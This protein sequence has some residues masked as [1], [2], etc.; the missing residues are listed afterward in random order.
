MPDDILSPYLSE[1]DQAACLHTLALLRSLVTDKRRQLVFFVG[2]GISIS[3]GMPLV[4]DLLKVLLMDALKSSAPDKAESDTPVLEA[5]KRASQMLGFEITLNS[6]WDSCPDAIK[7]LF[8]SLA[9]FEEK[10]CFPNN[11]HK[12]L[13]RWL[14]TS[15]VVLTTNYDR[16][17]ERTAADEAKDLLIRYTEAVGHASFEHWR[18]DLFQG[19][20]LFK[21]HGSF[22]EP[23]SCLGALEQVGT[24][25]SG[26]RGELLA[27]IAEE[28]PICFIGW[29]GVDPD[30]PLLLTEILSK[31]DSVPV[32]WVHYEGGD[33]KQPK[34]LAQCLSGVPEPLR[35]I[36]DTHPLITDADRL[37]AEMGRWLGWGIDPAINEQQE[38][39]L[40]SPS[41]IPQFSQSLDICTRTYLARFVGT[42]LRHARE[43][44][45][46]LEILEVA[47]TL[48]KSPGES[49]AALSEKSLTL[50]AQGH[51]SQQQARTLL[52]RTHSKYRQASFG[53]LSMTV[54]ASRRRPWL[55]LRLPHLFRGYALY[56]DELR[57]SA[58]NLQGERRVALHEALF[59]LYLGKLRLQLVSWIGS[60]ARP[61]ASWVLEPFNI[62]RARIDDAGDIHI[63]S[64]IDVL[65]GRSLALA[66][67]GFCEE[68][69][70]D[71]PEVK[72]LCGILAD[73]PRTKHFF[74]NQ[75]PKLEQMCTPPSSKI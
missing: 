74:E 42:A 63:H 20:C 46:A 4:P 12:F 24:K 34:G 7:Q 36:A 2:A 72:R 35:K 5:I 21:V 55:L 37:F 29:R 3:A 47:H 49:S 28:R 8:H 64:R 13:E 14:S 56:I 19:K 25:I 67:F 59:H 31:K 40:A 71:I 48:A 70:R 58:Y 23:E 50:W 6:L 18:E 1:I 68:A 38:I 54:V 15:G 66:R 53:M 44:E 39:P 75:L 60:L 43:F 32:I 9:D 69:W 11:A 51:D 27:A 52:K 45:A 10:W 57:A 30:V 41:M 62:A 16:L 17:I 73:Q 61:L 22:A 26:K 33:K 65:S